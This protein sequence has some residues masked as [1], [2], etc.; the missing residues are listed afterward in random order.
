MD[1]KIAQDKLTG[2]RKEAFLEDG[3]EAEIKRA[4]R[5]RRPLTFLLIDSRI[6]E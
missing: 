6:Y 2:I 3:V 4:E 5:Y 1:S